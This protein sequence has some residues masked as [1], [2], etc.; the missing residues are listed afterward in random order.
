ML[1][2]DY[3]GQ[4]GEYASKNNNVTH[5]DIVVDL[6]NKFDSVNL[7]FFGHALRLQRCGY[8]RDF[9]KFS[10][11]DKSDDSFAFVMGEIANMAIVGSRFDQ[12]ED[13]LSHQERLD[14]YI[15][16]LKAA[17]GNKTVANKF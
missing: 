15:T 13:I 1:N 12:Y 11:I 7:C 5:K 3:M 17:I 10:Y 9:T 4:V 8:G 14:D 16:F 6:S 2:K